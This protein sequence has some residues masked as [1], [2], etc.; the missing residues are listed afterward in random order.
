MAGFG[1]RRPRSQPDDD[2]PL[3]SPAEQA[4]ASRAQALRM[5]ERRSFSEVELTR[6]LTEKGHAPEVAAGT[7][8]RMVEAGFVNDA[9]YARQVART[10][11]VSRRASVRRVQQEMMRRGIPRT[12]ADDAIAEVRVDEGLGT[13]DASVER[14]ARQKLKSLSGLDPLT[15]ARRLTAFLSRRGF[16]GDLIRVTLRR[17]D[18]EAAAEGDDSES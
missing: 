17:L 4:A 10:F 9:T 2:A 16:S 6:R 8:V 7:V 15:R 11:L 3:P 14:A 12:M 13:E 5:L 18:R 1:S